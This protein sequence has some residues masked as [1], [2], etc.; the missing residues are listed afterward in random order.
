MKKLLFLLFIILTHTAFSQKIELQDLLPIKDNLINY[1]GIIQVDSATKNALYKK[2]KAWIS[3]STRTIKLELTYDDNSEE[4]DSKGSMYIFW[5]VGFG[6]VRDV[7]IKFT[8]KINAK[9]NKIRY[10]ITNF[11]DTYIVDNKLVQEPME[12]FYMD[13][14][15]DKKVHDFIKQIDDQIKESISSLEKEVK[16]SND[17]W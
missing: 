16:A 11:S 17:N 10:E 3:T 9:D 6:G 1:T 8:I 13:K 15:R 2:S 4:V 7:D 14:E 5:H 12:K